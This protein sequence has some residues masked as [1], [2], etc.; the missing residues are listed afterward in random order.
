MKK[1][2][3]IFIIIFT[4][5]I[6]SENNLDAF[7]MSKEVAPRYKNID[8]THISI[9]FNDYFN[10]NDENKKN[11]ELDIINNTSKYSPPELF[12]YANDL[13]VNG[14]MDDAVFWFL[15]ADL[16][17]NY[18]LNRA[19]DVTVRSG[20]NKIK[21]QYGFKISRY[22]T[23]DIKSLKKIIFKVMDL[24]ENTLYEYNHEWI[25]LHSKNITNELYKIKFSHHH[26]KWSTLKKI[27]TKI[28]SDKLK[29]KIKILNKIKNK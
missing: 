22:M 26:S 19:V 24:D 21:T 2:L 9:F 6:L 27:A 29:N 14:R 1:I 3:Y 4:L 23:R 11:I 15:F 25:N 20:Y 8:I 28:F 13:F 17:G 7:G 10:S 16:R 5:P 18:D 12:A